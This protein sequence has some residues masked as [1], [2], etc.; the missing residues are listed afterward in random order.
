MKFPACLA[1]LL[2]SGAGEASAQALS[3]EPHMIRDINGIPVVDAERAVVRDSAGAAIRDGSGDPVRSGAPA[4]I[5]AP[6]RLAR[7]GAR[8]VDRYLMVP[9]ASSGASGRSPSIV[10]VPAPG[11]R[12]VDPGSE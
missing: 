10:G 4:A 7:E 5:E 9:S 6:G 12:D 2:L 11:R 8:E 1:V 3:G